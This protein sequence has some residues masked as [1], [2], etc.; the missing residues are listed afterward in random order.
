MSVRAST[1]HCKLCFDAL[2]ARLNHQ[3]TRHFE[4]ADS[5]P[6]FVTW[7]SRG[8]L[9]GCIGNL[10]AIPF[11]QGLI[12]YAIRAGFHDSRFDPIVESEV[13][14]LTVGVSLLVEFVQDKAWDDWE[15]GLHGI[16][17]RFDHGGEH[18]KAVFL[19]E[20]AT[21]QGW[22]KRQT[23]DALAKKSGFQ[24]RI[25]QNL[26]SKMTVETFVSSKAEMTYT[27][28]RNAVVADEIRVR[29]EETMRS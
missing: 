19:P 7:K 12:E 1:A 26:L 24:G 18:Y 3:P 14:K 25:D 23:I 15:V 13:S 6:L 4:Q 9:R 16:V 10:S 5:V 11:P 17:L 27:E 29:E 2:W 20:V 28:W 21:E 8:R 22:S